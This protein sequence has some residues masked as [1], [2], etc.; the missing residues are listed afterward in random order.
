MPPRKK[1]RDGKMSIRVRVFCLAL[2]IIGALNGL[3]AQTAP[4]LT[5]T[6]RGAVA[7]TDRYRVEIADGVVIAIVNKLTDEGYLDNATDLAEFVPHLPGGLGTQAGD[8]ACAAADKLYRWPWWEHSASATWVNQHVPD[9]TS[10]FQYTP[11]GERGATLAYAGLVH[12]TTRFSDE[13]FGLD[14]EIEE[15]TGD[16][17]LTPW[18]RSPRPG[19][20]AANL[21]VA[22]LAAAITA[23]APIF[24]GVRLDRNMGHALW[25]NAWGGYWDYAFIA[26]NGYKRGAVAVWTEDAELRHYK[27]LFYLVNPA[28]LSFSFAT[29]SLPPF[30]GLVEARAATPWRIQAFDKS[31]TQA[32][33]RFREWRLA[34]VKLA[35]R[36]D[37]VADISHVS[38]ISRG[39]KESLDR[40]NAYFGN[41]PEKLKRVANFAANVRKAKFDTAHYDNTPYD[42]FGDDMKHWQASGAKFMAY[43]QPMIMWGAPSETNEVFWKRWLMHEDADTRS[44]FQK[45][46][47][48]I[49]PLIDQHHL[50]HQGYQRW[51]LD[52]V[53]SYIQE[54]GAAGV[55]H[56][57]SYH[58]PIDRR[59]PIEKLGHM[60]S[61]QG[62]ADYFYKAQTENPDSV[63]STEH[64]TE[65]NNVGASLGIAGGILWGT[66][67]SMRLQRIRHGSCVSA[68]LAWPNGV[69]FSFPHYS[70]ITTRRNARFFNWGLDLMEQRAEISGG[71]LPIDLAPEALAALRNHAWVDYQ[72]TQTFVAYGLRPV[73]PEVFDRN[74][75]S[76][77]RGAADEDFRYVKTPWGSALVELA[78][79]GEET[80]HYSRIHGV[81]EAE[82]PG[83][84]YGWL[85]YN[86]DGPAGLHP[87]RYY[88]VDP[89]AERPQIY[90]S[91]ANRF[92]PG[93]Y[94]SY[95]EDCAGN[96]TFAWA[97]L[98]PGTRG[99]ITEVDE[100]LIHTPAKPA[101]ML[102]N[103]H[104]RTAGLQ[105]RGNGAWWVNFRVNDKI[106]TTTFA[107]LTEAAPAGFG[108]DFA[109]QVICRSTLED[110]LDLTDR[111]RLAAQLVF[112]R[113]NPDTVTIKT[114]KAVSQLLF[115]TRPPAESAGPGKMTISHKGFQEIYVNGTLNDGTIPFKTGDESVLVVLRGE[116]NPLRTTSATVKWLP[117]TPTVSND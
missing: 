89:R 112:E 43:L 50:G 24:D 79:D 7:E 12:G 63:H 8:D 6:E 42:G 103:G 27:T 78:A 94:E 5:A 71:Y 26:F 97:M 3:Y 98:R 58:C 116:F 1:E 91:P 10:A 46:A 53:K 25:V 92:V 73:F 56:D 32:A 64:M 115:A 117:D 30:E 18:A 62:M 40:L 55:Y 15:A 38:L 93:L 84:V 9:G 60:T 23:E 44:V 34:N 16:L 35:P 83:T 102:I 88:P 111:S 75:S 114:P 66:A 65:V 96:D 39:G 105:D 99:M 4:L 51:F 77:F 61:V 108:Q 20:Y 100:V 101:L 74:V 70:D 113:P 28:G 76:Y 48:T 31:W 21:V 13:T 87:E 29:M 86:A 36:P 81:H 82:N 72:R 47:D 2:A 49:V 41:D 19:V 90:F 110:N 17:L 67:P 85:M 57:Q 68:A 37:W 104:N 11:R 14:I 109:D 59:G 52:C 54:Y 33:A 106:G 22:P 45:D 80:A 95:V 69:L 107:L